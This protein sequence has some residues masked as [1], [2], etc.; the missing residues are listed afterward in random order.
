VILDVG[1]AVSIV[2]VMLAA[3]VNTI[4]P[5][6]TPSEST[7]MMDFGDGF[8]TG[9]FIEVYLYGVGTTAAPVANALAGMI[10]MLGLIGAVSPVT[11]AFIHG[12]PAIGV[13]V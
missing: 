12:T 10:M 4:R 13:V 3:G 8:S 7:I 11:I 5:F 6:L 1:L 9:M 2:T